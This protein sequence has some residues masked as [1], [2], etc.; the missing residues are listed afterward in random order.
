MI[1]AWHNALLHA[2]DLFIQMIPNP[3]P[4]TNTSDTR[5]TEVMGPWFQFKLKPFYEDFA[6]SPCPCVGLIQVIWLPFVLSFLSYPTFLHLHYVCVTFFLNSE[7]QLIRVAN[8]Q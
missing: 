1:Q 6:C 3:Y 7:I 5:T 8:L 4:K 2:L